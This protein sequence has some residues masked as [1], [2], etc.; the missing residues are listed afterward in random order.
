MGINGARSDLWLRW[1]QEIFDKELQIIQ[2]D[3]VILSYGSNDA[4]AT[5]FDPETFMQNYRALIRK[6]RRHNPN[7]VILMNKAKYVTIY[8]LYNIST[9]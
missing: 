4:I 2:Y 6:I 8:Q 5:K 9:M 3:L 1:T 7:A